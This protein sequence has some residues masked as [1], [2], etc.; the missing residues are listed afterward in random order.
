MLT[1]THDMLTHLPEVDEQH[2]AFIAYL[3][4]LTEAIELDTQA[5]HADKAAEFTQTREALY[6][7]GIY[8]LQ[9]FEFEE[10]MQEKY[11]YPKLNWHKELHS[12]YAAEYKKM[13]H[14]F[15]DNGTSEE[16]MQLLQH[17]MK[18]WIA[19]HIATAD[20]SFGKYVS[21]VILHPQK[22]RA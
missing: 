12:W 11:G 5:N 7:L 16:F 6:A 4:T 20:V 17:S 10:Q 3:N 14:E 13:L 15:H 21:D 2:R 18:N 8:I 1:L 22:H 19:R 9:H